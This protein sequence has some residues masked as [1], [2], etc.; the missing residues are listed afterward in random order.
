[1][2]KVENF[3]KKVLNKRIKVL[4]ACNYYYVSIY[5]YISKAYNDLGGDTGAIGAES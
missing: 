4:V 5:I 1:M 2:A 3:L